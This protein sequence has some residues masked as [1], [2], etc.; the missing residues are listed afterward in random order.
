M[1]KDDENCKEFIKG[2]RQFSSSFLTASQAHSIDSNPCRTFPISPP[3]QKSFVPI[4][5]I[6]P[7]DS[8]G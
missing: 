1:S 3:S 8:T 7:K 4:R 6:S 5:P 2:L